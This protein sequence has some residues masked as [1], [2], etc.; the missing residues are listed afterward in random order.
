MSKP[1]LKAILLEVVTAMSQ[2][3]VR[4]AKFDT[5]LGDLGQITSNITA[6]LPRNYNKITAGAKVSLKIESKK[7][8][9]VK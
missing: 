9:F 7:Q 1:G 5:I 8:K 4:R 3:N 6:G 2:R